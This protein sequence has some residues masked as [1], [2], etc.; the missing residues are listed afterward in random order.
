M[1]KQ[2]ISSIMERGVCACES[3]CWC[4]CLCACVCVIEKGR[5]CCAFFI[6]SMVLRHACVV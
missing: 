6:E 5:C 4:V 2:R 3:A 1:G